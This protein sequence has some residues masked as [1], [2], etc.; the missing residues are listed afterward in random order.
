[1]GLLQAQVEVCSWVW[2]W[3]LPM[4][5]PL[6]SPG[7]HIGQAGLVIS[8]AA[9]PILQYSPSQARGPPAALAP[10]STYNLPPSHSPWSERWAASASRALEQPTASAPSSGR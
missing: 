2:R 9:G 3:A 5:P 4:M 1:M 8:R 10:L 7:R 6:G